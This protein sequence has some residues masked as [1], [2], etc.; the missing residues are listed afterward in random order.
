MSQRRGK[1]NEI[2]S[3]VVMTSAPAIRASPRVSL[4]ENPPR[5]RSPW[6]PASK[7]SES[8]N[9][10]SAAGRLAEIRAPSDPLSTQ[11][12]S[13]SA[14]SARSASAPNSRNKRRSASSGCTAAMTSPFDVTM[15]TSSH[16][17]SATVRSSA[18]ARSTRAERSTRSR[19]EW[20]EEWTFAAKSR[21]SIAVSSSRA[22]RTISA[23]RSR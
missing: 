10:R 8:D 7:R 1:I 5:G 17:R 3:R 20:F 4:R 2:A 11:S 19:A 15:S 22:W 18:A 9:P 16:R 21:S 23:A 6:T 12:W 14:R 13:R